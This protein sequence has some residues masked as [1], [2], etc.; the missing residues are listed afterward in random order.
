MNTCLITGSTSGIGKATALQLAKK[1]WHIILHGRKETLCQQSRDEIIRETGN[2]K[3]A[4]IVADL[5]LMK[6]VEKVVKEIEQKFP[7]LNILVNNA[8]TVS[9]NRRL[10]SEGI[11]LTWAVNY[12]SRFL[13]TNRLLNLLQKNAPSRII[14]VAGAYHAKGQIHFDDINLDKNYSFGM[15]NSQAKLANVLFTYKLAEKL[16]GTKVTVN[17][18]HPGLLERALSKRQKMYLL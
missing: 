11:E 7:E 17:C 18:L 2:T 8:G 10:T 4:Y 3:I 9:L 1:N 14:D 16:K 15:A 5:S 13:L 12:L 6:E